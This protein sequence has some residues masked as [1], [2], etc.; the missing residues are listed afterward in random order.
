MKIVFWGTPE[1]CI[2]TINSLY[3]SNHHISAIITQPDKRR[4]RG[5]KLI[6]SATK[7]H[8]LKLGIPVFTPEKIRNNIQFVNQ[9]LKI[10]ADI[11]IVIAYGKI[12]PKEILDIPRLYSWNAH[13]SLLPLLRGAAPIQWSLING[14]KTT[15]VSIIKM[16]EGVDTGDIIIKELVN[17]SNTDNIESLKNKLSVLSSKL[18]INLLDLIEENLNN[19]SDISSL[20]TRQ[21]SKPIKPTY[22]RLINKDDF[23]ID[24]FATGEQIINKI[25]GL[26]PNAYTICKDKRLKI[27][28]L[29]KF[30]DPSYVYKNN[31]GE[32]IDIIKNKGILVSNKQ[33]PLLI[34]EAQLEG[35]KPSSNNILIQQTKLIKGDKFI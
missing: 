18:I 19:I 32:I 29:E 15:G 3:H 26:Y 1:Y 25:R 10:N 5:S 33:Y 30:I 24:W 4:N 9:L 22:A 8:A 6:E 13:A 11:Y 23:L 12:L 17:I 7:K 27:I 35:K 21:E 2:N 14:D 16:D 20:L 28:K 34:T 31:S